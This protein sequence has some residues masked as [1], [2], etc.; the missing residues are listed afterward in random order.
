MRHAMTL[1]DA[2]AAEDA[3]RH[4]KANPPLID[5]RPIGASTVSAEYEAGVLRFIDARLGVLAIYQLIEH[6]VF[7]GA[8][9]QIWRR[10]D[11]WTGLGAAQ[12]A[13]RLP[14]PLF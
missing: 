1:A 13:A 11:V 7:I 5:G 14:R 6:F 9:V 4:F 10:P 2:L 12:F 3:E 8:A